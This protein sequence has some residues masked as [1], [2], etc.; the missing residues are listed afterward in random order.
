[1]MEYMINVLQ[2]SVLCLGKSVGGNPVFALI[3]ICLFY[4]FFSHIESQVEE[5]IFGQ[6]FQHW[7]DPVISILFMAYAVYAV[8]GC[9]VVNTHIKQ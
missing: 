3:V 8:Y 2:E 4:L 5:L 6:R 7:G 9:A 1:M